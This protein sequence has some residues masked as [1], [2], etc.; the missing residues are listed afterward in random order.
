MVALY[1]ETVAGRLA[2][3]QAGWIPLYGGPANVEDL[4]STASSESFEDKGNQERLVVDLMENLATPTGTIRGKLK[5]GLGVFMPSAPKDD[6]ASSI[7][8]KPK[9][10][11]HGAYLFTLPCHCFLTII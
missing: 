1:P 9:V 10:G 5:T 3:P 2:V 8:S 6:D 7:S 11:V 4:P